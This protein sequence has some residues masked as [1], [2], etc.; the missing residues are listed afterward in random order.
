ML[1]QSTVPATP[2]PSSAGLGPIDNIPWE[3][4]GTEIWSAL[5]CVLVVRTNNEAAQTRVTAEQVESEAGGTVDWD[6]RSGDET[7][8]S[9]SDT[10]LV[11]NGA[12]ASMARAWLSDL[13][14][15]LQRCQSEARSPNALSNSALCRKASNVTDTGSDGD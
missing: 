3:A 11:A 15:E 14:R 9:V 12:A 10:N 8:F 6:V 5:T 1:S 13:S 4:Q 2:Q 7:D